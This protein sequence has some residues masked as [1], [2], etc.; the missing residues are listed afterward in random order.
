MGHVR[1]CKLLC[2]MVLL[3][4]AACQ[5][6][7][8][9]APT[10]ATEASVIT[11]LS[12]QAVF[13]E[14]LPTATEPSP[15]ITAAPEP[16][17]TILPPEPP[18]PVLQI[19][20][21]LA[22]ESIPELWEIISDPY[23]PPPLG[24]DERHQGVDFSHWG[25]RD[26]SSI[27]GEVIQVVLPGVVA[28]AI[29]DRLPY[30]NMVMIET[31][32]TEL[33]AE[34][35]EALGIAEGESLYHLYAH[36]QNPPQLSLDQEVVCG[37]ALGTVGMSGYNIVNPHLHLEMRLGPAGARFEGMVFYDTSATLEEMDAYRLWRMSGTF[38]HF[39]PMELFRL[40]STLDFAMLTRHL[41]LLS[42]S[43]P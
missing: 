32:G 17:A 6:A 36:M 23:N 25:R 43:F 24:R 41:S 11:P 21:P 40:T 30:G 37:E 14:S 22:E 29:H 13:P 28:A 42:N 5:P 16:T 15:V 39:D 18:V 31:P 3:L 26:R 8:S 2:G 4:A 33:P 7:Y 9:V 27:E 34:I 20:S 1:I 10:V 19:C 38:R 35:V 12:P